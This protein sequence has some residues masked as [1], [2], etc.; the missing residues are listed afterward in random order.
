MSLF[1]S[2]EVFI[3]SPSVFDILKEFSSYPVAFATDITKKYRQL[4]GAENDRKSFGKKL[5][6]NNQKF[7]N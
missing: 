5:K 7:N 1:Y 6:I 4:I 2:A 3:L